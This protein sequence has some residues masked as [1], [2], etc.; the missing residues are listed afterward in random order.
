MGTD[1][2]G[3]GDLL[4]EGVGLRRGVLVGVVLERELAVRPLNLILG[5]ALGNLQHVVVALPAPLPSIFSRIKKHYYGLNRT[6]SSTQ[7]ST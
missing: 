2:V 4:E 6:E 7:I 1:V 3:L 5:R